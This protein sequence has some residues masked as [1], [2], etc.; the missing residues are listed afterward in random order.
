M[1]SQINVVK[2][3]GY[4]NDIDKN[5]RNKQKYR[6]K[7]HDEIITLSGS[8]RDRRL[9]G[10]LENGHIK[11]NVFIKQNFQ[12]FQIVIITYKCAI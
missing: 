1:P 5:E 6:R 4:L 9:N 3:T 7:L 11:I 10:D 12:N 2:V 8:L